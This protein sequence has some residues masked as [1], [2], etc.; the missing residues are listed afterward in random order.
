MG[1]YSIATTQFNYDRVSM[2]DYGR[3][4]GGM[5]SMFTKWPASVGGEIFYKARQADNYADALSNMLDEDLFLK[6]WGP[7]VAFGVAEGTLTAVGADGKLKKKLLGPDISSWAPMSGLIPRE[8]TAGELL[9]SPAIDLTIKM[10][11]N[12][13]GIMSDPGSAPSKLGA[14]ASQGA[15]F[16]PGATW[17]DFI[18]K[19]IEEWADALGGD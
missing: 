1:R 19:D 13:Q 3:F 6:Y 12:L 18:L 14:A 2:N 4:M 15:A 16:V 11:K 8:G 17:V 10:G 5:F 9:S 7:L